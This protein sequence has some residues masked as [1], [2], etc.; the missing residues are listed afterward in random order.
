[1][2]RAG[3]LES[4]VSLNE[5]ACWSGVT[6]GSGSFIHGDGLLLGPIPSAEFAEG[7]LL[8]FEERGL[9]YRI[10]SRLNIL[11]EVEIAASTF[12]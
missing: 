10:M 5:H 4:G 9:G 12:E 2:H 7:K 8:S 11:L 3:I 1:M 6:T